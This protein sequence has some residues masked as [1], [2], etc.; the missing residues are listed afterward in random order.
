[1]SIAG[2]NQ[3]DH[4]RGR[5]A[6]LADRLVR[7]A[8]HW[9]EATSEGAIV[10][11]ILVGFVVVWMIFWAVSTAPVDVPS[12]AG[13]A[14]VWA[15]HFAFGYKH[16]PMTAWFFK[17]WF[18][19]FPRQRWASDLLVVTND[20]VGL[21][22]AW[23]LLRDHL[24]KYRALLGLIALILIPLYTVKAEVLNANTVMIPF[25]PATL[26]FY[27]RARRSLGMADAFLAGAFASLTLLGK[28]W[29]VFLF[30]GMAVAA[31]VGPGARRFWRSPAPYV[32]AAG[33]I[34]VITPHVWWTLTHREAV[35]FAKS[36]ITAGPFS[37]KL[38]ASVHYILS[39]IAWV[40]VS[41]IFLAALKPSRAAWRDIA[42]PTDN[43]RRQA[44]VLLLAP[45]ILPALINLYIPYRITSDW[46]VPNWALLPIVLYGSHYLTIDARVAARAGVIGLMIVLAIVIAAPAIAYVRLKGDRDRDRR[47]SHRIAET[48]KTL[49]SRPITSIWGSNKFISN[50]PF[51]LPEA[52]LS[53]TADRN[54]SLLIVCQRDDT[55]CQDAAAAR[56]TSGSRS[57]T[58]TYRRS[59]LGFEGP[60][61]TFQI[62]V[63]PPNS[64][65]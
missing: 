41:L 65:N 17:V 49:A 35:S 15:Q 55:P 51:Y 4:T 45:L 16:P 20:A 58:V 9:I 14:T 2:H 53:P 19:V 30:A 1:M 22:I 27:L 8:E 62:T 36:V 13:E 63:A 52:R 50:L 31:L 11:T 48:A 24:D 25:W 28:Y 12:D 21:A 3:A 39:A 26:L 61:E 33:A 23:R 18:A 56:A 47:Y 64:S 29:A 34:V 54:G 42:W 44:L 57:A 59:F 38:G 6:W 37:E 10:S 32:M 40:I 60:P 43:D 7:T 5:V 46:T